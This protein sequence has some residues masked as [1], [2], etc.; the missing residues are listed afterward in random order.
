MQNSKLKPSAN[1]GHQKDMIKWIK[2]AI[3]LKDVSK[4]YI[5][6]T[7][8]FVLL[9]AVYVNSIC[10]FAD[11]ILVN[12]VWTDWVRAERATSV[13]DFLCNWM[14]CHAFYGPIP[15]ERNVDY[16]VEDRA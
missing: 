10:H 14:V 5:G 1:W 2:F 11:H 13:L 8:E 7:D 4:D 15:E 16:A 12:Y 3:N 9:F 6:P